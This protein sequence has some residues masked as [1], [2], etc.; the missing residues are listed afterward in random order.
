M[1]NPDDTVKQLTAGHGG[2][3]GEHT[4]AAQ[5]Q[6]NNQS[7]QRSRDDEQGTLEYVSRQGSETASVIAVSRIVDGFTPDGPA[8]T[9][10]PD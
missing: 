4:P 5:Y 10:L 1:Q 8:V 7:D 6:K 9:W 2:Q 3:S